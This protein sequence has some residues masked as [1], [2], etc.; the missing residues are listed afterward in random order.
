MKKFF[1][2]FALMAIA[3]L[4]AVSCQ[5]DVETS[6]IEPDLEF[7]NAGEIHN[8]YLD[9]I[10]SYLNTHEIFTRADNLT[11]ETFAQEMAKIQ[12][13]VLTNSNLRGM[14]REQVISHIQR[15]IDVSISPDV[16]SLAQ[17][18]VDNPDMSILSELNKNGELSPLLSNYV[19]EV[20]RIL[21]SQT[22]N[23][24]TKINKLDLI[25]LNYYREAN[26]DER[27]LI[28]ATHDI[29]KDSKEYWEDNGAT[30]ERAIGRAGTLK[31]FIW[32][33]AR[34]DGWALIKAVYRAG[35]YY[36][37]MFWKEML[38]A[39]GV[40]S[41]I[42]A[43]AT[44]IREIGTSSIN[45]EVLYSINGSEPISESQLKEMILQEV[46]IQNPELNLEFETKK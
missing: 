32:G 16:I 35:W 23:D 41:A 7:E 43:V 22:I 2:R 27:K 36:A 28:S 21:T 46:I 37:T 10:L 18:L 42:S 34:A 38:I 4:F 3:I 15:N 17:D 44:I 11:P 14:S 1:Y 26:P 20:D 6:I 29:F 13:S 30:W 24:V 45:G 33:V 40:A 5:K 9:D 8:S 39:S 31:G 25:Y 19:T 12:S